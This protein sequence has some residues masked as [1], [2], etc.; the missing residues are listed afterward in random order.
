[1]K[2]A[3]TILAVLLA[4]IMVLSVLPAA[5]AENAKGSKK[6][7]RTDTTAVEQAGRKISKADKYMRTR[8]GQ[9][10][11]SREIDPDTMVT[12]IVIFEDPALSDTFTAEEIR[13]KKAETAQNRLS[14]AHDTFFKALSFEAKRLYDYT[15]LING[16]SL[17]TA[18]KNLS[19]MEKMNGVKKVYIANEYS[20]P[21]V[22]KP[23]QANAN[24]MTGAFSMQSIG[25]I[26]D[27]MVVAVLDTG[28]NLEHEA[29][30]DYGLITEPAFTQ[31]YVESVA[32]T[33][34]GKYVSA[35]IP[36]AYDYYF[37]EEAGF[38]PDDDVTDYNG[39]GTHVSGT[40]TG[41]ALDADGGIKFM[42]A[43]PAAQLVFMKIFS[44]D[45]KTYSGTNS[46]IYMAA[47]EDAFLLG[48]DAI[49]MSIGSPAGFTYDDGLEGEFGNVYRKLDQA[50]IIVCI[51]AGNEYSMAHSPAHFAGEG[52]VMADY[53]DY[54]EVGTPSTYEGNVSVASVENLAYPTYVLMYNGQPISYVDN[55]EDGEHGWLDNFAGETIEL[56]DCG[57]GNPDEIPAEVE[58]KVALVSR[59]DISFS[60]KNK[61]VADKGAIGM[62]LYNNQSGTIGMLINPYYIP[63]VSIQQVDGQMILAG[64]DADNTLEV[65]DE[66]IELENPNAWL[67]SDFSSWGCTPNLELKPTVTAPG[68][69]IYSSVAGAPDAY[70]VYSGTSMASPNACGSFLLLAQYLKET[71]PSLSKV[72]RAELA[73]DLVESSADLPFDGDGYLYSPRK[74]GSGLL[75]LENAVTTPVYFIEP[76]VN[77]YDDPEKTG[78]YQFRYTL[79]NLT[80]KDQTYD[81]EVIG[82]YDYPAQGSYGYYNTLTSDYL[83]DGQGLEFTGDTKVT[84]P[85]NGTF[86]GKITLKLQDNAKQ[87]FD[88]VYPNGNYFEGYVYLVNED[89]SA[90][91]GSPVAEGPL[92][93][94]NLDGKVTAADAAEILRAVVGLTELDA[95]QLFFADVNQDGDVTAADAAYILRAVVGLEELASYTP[96]GRLL[97][98]DVHMTFMGFYGDWKQ[99]PVFDKTWS[100]TE[101]YLFG[102]GY[103]NVTYPQYIA[104]GYLPINLF[105]DLET[106]LAVSEI[107]NIFIS[108]S[109]LYMDYDPNA[110]DEETGAANT[111]YA[112]SGAHPLTFLKFDSYLN[113]L[114]SEEEMAQLVL[115]GW[116]DTA[117]NYSPLHNAVSNYWGGTYET[118]DGFAAFPIQLRNARHAIMT[119]SDA[120]TGEIYYQQDDEWI[121]KAY[122]SGVWGARDYY[123]WYGV[124][125]NEESEG[126]GDLVPSGT[127]VNVTFEAQIDYPDAELNEEYSFQMI[128]DY[129]AP[130]MTDSRIEETDEG[131]FIVINFADNESGVAF[132]DAF[133]EDEEGNPVVLGYAVGEEEAGEFRI[134]ITDLPEDVGYI[135]VD[136]MDYATNFPGFTIEATTGKPLYSPGMAAEMVM[137]DP[138]AIGTVIPV[139]GYVSDNFNGSVYM[140]EELPEKGM[141]FGIEVNFADKSVLDEIYPGS[142]YVIVGELDN[143]YGCPR[144]D[145]AYISIVVDP[146]EDDDVYYSYDF[147]DYCVYYPIMYELYGYSEPVTFD[148]L[149]ED[150]AMYCGGIRYFEDLEVIGV[151]DCEDGTRTITLTNGTNCIDVVGCEAGAE[152]TYVGDMLYYGY[153]VMTFDHGTFQFHPLQGG[154]Y[155][156]LVFYADLG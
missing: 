21:E 39:H 117:M 94:V 58:G 122:L 28:L 84:V 59:G 50:G 6:I 66:K 156:Y 87:Y 148:D 100:N 32:T 114:F 97:N 133:Y 111:L 2:K 53:A 13:A 113:Q 33:V 11:A 60:E 90:G 49:N 43:A 45:T 15:A 30:Q 93:D 41:F 99:A 4:V 82:L 48:V 61:N 72:Q 112:K 128:L 47:L 141:Y 110:P 54:G 65:L 35:K 125:E 62:V 14:N 116:A 136:V 19:A 24:I 44:D 52:Y 64:L 77:L 1:M 7:D 63:A 20:A 83:F 144:L 51:S 154:N 76:I 108:N 91:E 69:M 71:Y 81:L 145:N 143:Y 118:V 129:D 85:A 115:E 80:D 70:E 101:D 74:S 88:A 105:P 132:A 8:G 78:E 147:Y 107:N 18:Y 152:N 106:N 104:A 124:N 123:L 31:E 138:D 23:T 95:I 142:S 121:G 149:F 134:D 79:V 12:A 92:G 86:D 40:I 153:F 36:F 68:G 56:V 34:E 137:T 151:T 27:G 10:L 5:F 42:G 57:F 29:F 130:F 26:G 102:L 120:E 89:A 55:C 146:Y 155:E 46:G 25:L 98:T 73:E 140:T 103:M 109:S 67:M 16:M 119:V 96:T 37:N 75:N 139:Y 38:E 126:Y 131:K 150:P 22:Q 9:A 17:R 135:T 127:I 3:R